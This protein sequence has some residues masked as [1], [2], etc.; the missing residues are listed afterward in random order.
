MTCEMGLAACLPLAIRLLGVMACSLPLA[1]FGSRCLAAAD[2]DKPPV[3]GRWELVPELSD[4]FGGDHLDT[5]KWHDMNPGWQGR[6][7]LI[8]HPSCVSLRGGELVLA[9]QPAAVSSAST[10]LPEGFTHIG[11]YVKS[12]IPICHGYFEI[13]ARLMDASLVSGFWLYNATEEEW[14]E[15]DIVEVPAGIDSHRRGLQTN[16]HLFHS[17]TYKGTV[18]DHIS[19]SETWVAPVDL[20]EDF[21]VYGLHWTEERIEWLFDGEVIRSIPNE[22]WHQPLHVNLN[23]EANP[24]FGA[25]PRDSELPAEYR[26]DYIRV[27]RPVTGAE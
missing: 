6:P 25:L 17:P 7:P 12:K 9:A 27:W 19:A 26:V 23:V 14:T 1:W 5:G 3:E 16:A 10:D 20:A 15:I 11:G 2:A 21:H 13:R 24:W 18:E 22:H 8:F 4:T